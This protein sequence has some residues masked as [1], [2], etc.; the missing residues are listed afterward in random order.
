MRELAYHH[1]FQVDSLAQMGVVSWLQGQSPVQGVVYR[2]AQPWPRADGEYV[3]APENPS[4]S[5][6]VGFSS[7]EP[8]P[9]P[10][11]V[12]EKDASVA[13]LKRQLVA[14]P[15][16]IVE[17]LQP[18]EETL[19]EVTVPA[20][21]QET[22]QRPIH[23]HLASYLINQRLMLLT[24]LPLSFND[25]EALDKL[26]LSLARALLKQ[27]VDEWNKGQFV[28]PGRLK[29][30]YLVGRHDWAMGAFEQ[31]LSNQ[32]GDVAAPW[33]ILAGE[34]AQHYYHALPSDHLLYRVPVANVSSLAQMLRIPELRKE[35][36]QVMQAVFFSQ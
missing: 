23:A 1:A 12:E 22:V 3:A 9:A 20:Q 2:T 19:V 30:R 18:I 11:N 21:Q 28:W 26:A 10:V 4:L 14:A 8:A 15:D 36:W 24:D 29:N 31:F 27:E 5:V 35:A 6:D 32:L 34:Q 7:V 33:L 16:V 13:D 25:D 17:D